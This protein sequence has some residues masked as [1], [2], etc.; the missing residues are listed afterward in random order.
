MQQQIVIPAGKKYWIAGLHWMAGEE[1]KR[2]EALRQVRAAQ[3][4]H[5]LVL[6]QES[7]VLIGTANLSMTELSS[8][9]RRHAYALAPQLIPLL[10]DNR[11]A[12]FSLGSNQY[13]F[14][15]TANGQL[16]LLSDIA[17]S[18]EEVTQALCRF[19]SY[20]EAT[21]TGAL[22]CPA[23][24][25]PDAEDVPAGNLT[26]FLATA[27]PGKAHRLHS[28][29]KKRPVMLWLLA[30]S[31]LAAV[32]YG[33]SEWQEYQHERDLEAR[34]NALAAAR[35]LI[36]KAP[37]QPWK[38]VPI[39]EDFI[40]GCTNAWDVPLSLAGWLFREAQCAINDSGMALR[41]AWHRPAGGTL[42]TFKSRLAQVYPG[43]RPVF[44]IPGA[45]DIG[46]VRIS[47]TP[48]ALNS[49][50]EAPSDNEEITQRLTNYAQQIAAKLTLTENGTGKVLM[51]GN[52]VELPWR[53]FNFQLQTDIPPA[54]LFG[55]DFNSSG[56]RLNAI[57]MTLNDARLHYSLEGTLY[58]TR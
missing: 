6:K 14:V 13:Y 24:F 23:G 20:T 44:N 49:G 22:Y 33:I 52:M 48:A 39:P 18:R 37:P 54:R 35:T 41:L 56:I 16:S 29:S 8:R 46:G 10:G 4:D 5:Y 3:A 15:A 34:R 32:W 12:I 42:D 43:S 9:Q 26:E 40:R 51:D 1:D 36:Q 17:G 58:A 31:T 45:A 50:K 2:R 28:R 27:T 55:A 19:L 21:G 57:T 53:T 30:F 47:V 25:W 38:S 7:D 11:W